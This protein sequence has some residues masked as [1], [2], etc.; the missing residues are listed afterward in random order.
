ML[1][2]ERFPLGGLDFGVKVNG[3]L[4]TSGKS[5]YSNFTPLVFPAT[6]GA[7]NAIELTSS[8]SYLTF[9]E[10]WAV[11]ID[12]NHDQIFQP[13]EKVFEGQTTRPADG[14]PGKSLIANFSLPAQAMLGNA[15]MRVAMSRGNNLEPCGIIPFGEVED[16]TVNITPALQNEEFSEKATL[17]T[18]PMYDFSL[19]PNPARDQITLELSAWRDRSVTLELYNMLGMRVQTWH[20]NKITEAQVLIHLD[21]IESG[22]Y[23]LRCLSPD[24]RRVTKKVLVQKSY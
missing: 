17:N 24:G 6:I 19:F 11:W 21:R 7:T 13:G 8:W 4:G 20:F 15:R 12:Y 23:L 14:T 5:P 3:V 18:E 10:N 16:Y 1:R 2:L 22:Q 9:D